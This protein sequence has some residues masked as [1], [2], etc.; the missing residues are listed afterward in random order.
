MTIAPRTA[1]TT[2]P[3]PAEIAVRGFVPEMLGT[4]M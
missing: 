1:S 2:E 4:A 3:M